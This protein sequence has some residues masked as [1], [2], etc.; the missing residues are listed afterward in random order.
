MFIH[1]LDFIYVS[2]EGDF[3]GA[4]FAAAIVQYKIIGKQMM[5][6]EGLAFFV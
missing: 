3:D 5:I 4:S 1:G 6:N 2:V